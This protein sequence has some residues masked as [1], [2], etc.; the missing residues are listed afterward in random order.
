M[1]EHSMS[2]EVIRLATE[3]IR[4]DGVT[5]SYQAGV[6]PALAD[7]SMEV[8]AGEVVAVMGPSGSG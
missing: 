4:L 3:V 8:A 1:R 6:T 7:V 2:G 5:K